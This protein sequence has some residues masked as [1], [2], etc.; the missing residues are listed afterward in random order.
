MSNTPLPQFVNCAASSPVGLLVQLQRP[1]EQVCCKGLTVIGS[2]TRV[3][4]ASLHCAD[5]GKHRGWLPHN[6]AAAI[7]D[8]IDRFGRPT[9]PI[10]LKTITSE[11]EPT[12]AKDAKYDNRGVLFLNDKKSGANDPTY[13]GTINVGGAEYWLS[14]WVNTSEKTGSKYVSLSVRSKDQPNGKSKPKPDQSDEVFGI[15]S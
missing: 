4:A 9:E 10:N 11:E 5:C 12:M 14:A 15:S 1:F 2:S 7:T 13:T 8:I 3:H 6:V